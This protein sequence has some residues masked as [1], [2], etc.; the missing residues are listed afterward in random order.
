[1]M[2]RALHQGEPAAVAILWVAYTSD[3]SFFAGLV[4]D[5][6]V[7]GAAFSLFMSR[8]YGKYAKARSKTYLTNDEIRR[9]S[10]EAARMHRDYFGNEVIAAGGLQAATEAILDERRGRNTPSQLPLTHHALQCADFPPPGSSPPR[11]FAGRASTYLA[12]RPWRARQWSMTIRHRH[13]GQDRRQASRR[14]GPGCVASAFASTRMPGP[15]VHHGHPA[16]LDRSPV[17]RSPRSATRPSCWRCCWRHA[18]ASRWP[19]I[20]RHPR[21]DA[22]QPC[23]GRLARRTGWRTGCTPEVLRWSVA[24]S[25]LRGRVVDAEAGQARRRRSACPH[26]APS[27]PRR[28]HSSSSRSATRPRWPP[29]CWRRSTHPAVAG[30]RRHYAGHGDRERAGGAAG[31]ALRR[32]SCRSRR[33]ASPRRPS[34]PAWRSG[35]R[36]A[37]TA[38]ASPTPYPSFT[39][40]PPRP[41]GYPRAPPLHRPRPPA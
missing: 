16:R 13:A 41:P 33:R 4:P 40:P 37:R 14:P 7:R 3:T 15:G 11:Q 18:S 17:A 1:M 10:E 5:D 39:G 19:I 36:W 26:A 31:L 8:L 29:W 32:R 21:R 20:A 22:A 9:A 34:S 38:P 23:A 6:R 35:W 27:S 30:D 25:F 2:Q 12:G 28:S 24:A